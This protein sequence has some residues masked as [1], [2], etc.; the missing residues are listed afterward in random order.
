MLLWNIHVCTR[1]F[2]IN[3]GIG[4]VTGFEKIDSSLSV[5]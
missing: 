5:I 4:F 2:H 3:G 1:E